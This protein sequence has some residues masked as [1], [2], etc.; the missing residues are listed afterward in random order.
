MEELLTV[1]EARKKLKIGRTNLYR[2][3][4]DKKLEAKKLGN[5]TFI[6]LASI[7]LFISSLPGYRD[8]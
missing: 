7:N 8:K 6:P 2:L 1:T 4:N 5:K 3:M